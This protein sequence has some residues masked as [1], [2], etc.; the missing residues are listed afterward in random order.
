[1]FIERT[2]KAKIEKAK[3]PDTKDIIA[4]KKKRLIENI[5]KTLEADKEE[6]LVELTR[7]LLETGDVHD[8]MYALLKIGHGR[9][10]SEET[11][12]N[13]I[14]VRGNERDSRDRGNTGGQAGRLFVAK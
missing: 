6:H 2:I 5:T 12:K 10:F 8:I 14:E 3:L 9:D 1:M 13:I 7:G 11:Y 4:G